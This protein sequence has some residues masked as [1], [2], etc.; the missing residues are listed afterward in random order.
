MELPTTTLSPS[1]VV[2]KDR[3]YVLHGWGYSP[4]VL[5]AGKGAI[6]RDING[7]EYIDCIS[8]TAGPVGIGHNHPKW[9]KAVKDQ[10]DQVTHTLTFFI[11]V[12]R[13]E[14]AEKLS[15]IAPGKMKNNIKTY[16]SSGGSE[17]NETAI[18]FAMLSTKKKEVISIWGAYHGGTLA[19]MSLIGQYWHRE[20]Y[21][22]FPGFSQVPGAYSYRC[23]FG[24][25]HDPEECDLEVA[26]FLESH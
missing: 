5:V 1:E 24:R 26:E 15:D 17:A 18:K 19:L 13:V 22:R 14:L 3:E 23:P 9:L 20:G 25:S 16:F 4:I 12:P 10:M 6:V 11:N 21:V 7:K 2:S 8:Q